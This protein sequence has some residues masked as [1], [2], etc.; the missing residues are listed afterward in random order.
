MARAVMGVAS[1]LFQVS[2]LRSRVMVSVALIAMMNVR[3]S[4][5]ENV[6]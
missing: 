3:R 2:F 6:T 1:R 5:I 4:V